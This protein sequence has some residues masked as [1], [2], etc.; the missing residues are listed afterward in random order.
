MYNQLFKIIDNKVDF[1]P[2]VLYKNG[3]LRIM[4]LLKHEALSTD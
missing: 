4:Y 1:N 2:N 3:E